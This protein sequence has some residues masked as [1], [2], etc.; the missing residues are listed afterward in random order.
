MMK[1]RTLLFGA[2][3][4][5]KQVLAVLGDSIELI[6]YVD[7]DPNKWGSIINEVY[8]Y[9]P[10]IIPFLFFDQIAIAM[11]KGV[12]TVRD[13]LHSLGVCDSKIIVPVTN[14]TVF[15]ND[16]I[17]IEGEYFPEGVEPSLL[18]D[19]P[20]IVLRYWYLKHAS[21]H[22]H[23]WR[24]FGQECGVPWIQEECRK[25]ENE[26]ERDMEIGNRPVLSKDQVI[27][28]A[29][30]NVD[31]GCAHAD[32]TLFD[33][34]YRAE[35]EFSL[36][37]VEAYSSLVPDCSISVLFGKCSRSIET[38]ADLILSHVSPVYSMVIDLENNFSGFLGIIDE[39]GRATG[40]DICCRRLEDLGEFD[41]LK[42]HVLVFS[43]D[44]PDIYGRI[45][46]ENV[47]LQAEEAR[48]GLTVSR[49]RKQYDALAAILLSKSS[50]YFYG[51]RKR[52]NKSNRLFDYLDEMKGALIRN[53]IPLDKVCVTSG[54]VLCAFGMKDT[55]DVDLI[56]TKEFRDLYGKGLV[57][58]SDHVEVHPIDEL[59]V[60]DD[61]IIRDSRFHFSFCGVKF[62]NIDILHRRRHKSG[63]ADARVIDL[64]LKSNH[65]GSEMDISRR[66][67][68]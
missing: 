1:K 28:W 41:N 19:R 48:V 31:G 57:I 24:G 59:D 55:D 25:I 50:L 34:F 43:G 3:G 45:N 17:A 58:V 68:Y 30:S 4:T 21:S 13:Q 7:N 40:G 52:M 49:D 44:S 65:A 22:M 2:G 60:E 29:L 36:E 18:R 12:G 46:Q 37:L 33:L 38:V 6:G 27:A 26:V 51:A 35:M 5:A 15:F 56:M 63:S 67:V 47:I 11:L 20:E 23:S 32:A 9:Q 64:F 10:E 14:N 62:V 53:N 42:I 54:G 39:V 16:Q 8:I 66:A 61:V